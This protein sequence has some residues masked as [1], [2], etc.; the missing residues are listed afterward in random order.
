M[1]NLKIK[2]SGLMIFIIL[3]VLL[4]GCNQGSISENM[5]EFKYQTEQFGDTRILRYK[6]PEFD[7]LTLRQKTLIY[8][9]HEAALAGRDIFWD[10]NYR[11]NLTIRKTL[12]QVIEHYNGSRD[13]SDFQEFLLYAKKVFVNNGIHHHY[14]SQKI[15]PGFSEEYLIELVNNSPDGEF[16]LEGTE[17]LNS[18]LKLLV[19]ILFDPEIDGK[20]VN[21]N[22]N[23]DLA[24]TSAINYY[25]QVNQDEVLSFYGAMVNPNDTTP[26][27]HGLNS[28]LTKREGQ[29]VENIWRRNEMYSQAIEQ[30]IYWLE[31]AL[32]VA[33]NELQMATIQKLIDF[34]N[35]GDLVTFDEYSILWVQDTASEIDFTNGFIEVYNDPF[36]FKGAY[37]SMVYMVDHNAADRVNSISSNAQW[38]ENNMP[39]HDDFKKEQVTGISARAVN[40]VAV[41]GDNSPQPPLGVNLP[42]SD[43]IRREHGS[44][45]ITITNIAEAHHFANLQSGIAD[46]FACNQEEIRLA[47]E[48]GF[49][50]NN[51]HTDL[52]EIIGHG[53]GKLR[54]GVADMSITL[55]NYASVIEETRADL[56]ALYFMTDPKLVELGVLP[57]AEAAKAQYNHYIKNGLML[58]LYRVQPG[59]NIEQ[60]H[61]RNRQLIASKALEMGKAENVIEK[62]FKDGKTCITI[63]NYNRL[64]EIFGEMLKEIQRIKSEGDF[65]AARNLVETY[66]V[67]VDQE[68]LQEVHSR[69]NRM[70]MKPYSAFINP[71]FIP[72]VRNN[73]IVDVIIEYPENFLEQMLMYGSKYSLLPVL[74]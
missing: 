37:Q 36:G 60:A 73:R 67:Q 58:Q 45:S 54:A 72:V 23:E 11:H 64:R 29:V 55:K 7:K 57:T 46:E 32:S 1:N 69:Y 12:E 19:S 20:L 34:Y 43:W 16:P 39:F 30:I 68:L 62:T 48:Y 22:P 13:T 66:G 59:Q 5:N 18:L 24:G 33:E 51:V 47:N 42:N 15:I 3:S 41:S 9:L 21:L 27:M 74:N 61:M 31:R 8:Y 14:T 52:H 70:G 49:L 26:V 4:P 38:F 35:T 17:E 63:N 28:Q 50:T 25:S 10:Q 53:S 6:I 56:T 65:E 40:V 2:L 44:K 71:I